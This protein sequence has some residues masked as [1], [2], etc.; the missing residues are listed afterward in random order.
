MP[1]GLLRI[2][3]V[4]RSTS[5]KKR[6]EPNAEEQDSWNDAEDIE[7]YA[8]SPCSTSETEATSTRVQGIQKEEY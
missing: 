4:K 3:N 7:E 8:G 5:I 2:Q 6:L 1:D